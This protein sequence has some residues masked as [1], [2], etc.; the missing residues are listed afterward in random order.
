[1]GGWSSEDES[2]C[3]GLLEGS[4]PPLVSPLYYKKKGE[5]SATEPY[6][7]LFP[8]RPDPPIHPHIQRRVGGVG[9][10][11]EEKSKHM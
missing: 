7:N 6:T 11:V 9:G 8:S 10:W 5:T 2:V 1:M 4:L 3:L